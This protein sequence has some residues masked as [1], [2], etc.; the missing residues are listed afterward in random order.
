[1]ELQVVG[2]GLAPRLADIAVAE[3]ALAA[4]KI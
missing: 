2:D 1:L 4:R 3:G